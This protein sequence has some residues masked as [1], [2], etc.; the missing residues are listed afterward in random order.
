MLLKN[1]E[2]KENFNFYLLIMSKIVKK[3][4]S[5]KSS[6]IRY[7]NVFILSFYTTFIL[8]DKVLAAEVDPASHISL[9]IERVI[10]IMTQIGSA[11]LLL[12]IV[13]D[14]FTILERKDDPMVRSM[15]LRDV[16]LL[17]VAAI[18]LFNPNLIL[19]AIRFIANV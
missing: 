7:M 6:L 19:D 10:Q 15:I 3:I 4:L 2:V 14:A 11:V 13:K 8:T 9:I 17:I 1:L 5:K 18:F 16:F 12:Y